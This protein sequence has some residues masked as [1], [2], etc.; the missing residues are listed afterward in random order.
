[1]HTASQHKT[2]HTSR[3]AQW[4]RRDIWSCFAATEP[5]HVA[6][7]DPTMIS[8]YTKVFY[9]TVKWELICMTAKSWLGYVTGQWSQAYHQI[10]NRMTEKQINQGLA[11]AQ[12]KSRPQLH[13]NAIV[14]PWAMQKWKPTSLNELK[15]RYK[16]EWA[17]MWEI[18]KITENDYMLL[19]LKVLLKAT[20]S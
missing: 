8:S 2:P 6:F 11:V 13:R 7:I 5:E 1:M 9:S 3:Q 16:E 19:L 18:D 12:S 4:W 15:E 20:A 10:H 17:K 14:E